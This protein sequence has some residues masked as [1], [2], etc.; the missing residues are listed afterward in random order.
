MLVSVCAISIL[1]SDWCQ[2]EQLSCRPDLWVRVSWS[3]GRSLRYEYDQVANQISHDY[4][5]TYIITLQLLIT[6]A[7]SKSSKVTVRYRSRVPRITRHV[8]ASRAIW[9]K[10]LPSIWNT[11]AYLP[12]I[13]GAYLIYAGVY[14]HVNF[15]RP[16]KF[17]LGG[18]WE[19]E[20]LR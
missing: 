15:L 1:V 14:S 10:I 8:L 9:P 16:R 4:Y 19:C 3:V 20:T 2:K 17:L 6:L 11:C 5:I 18:V 7:N 13:R 12:Q